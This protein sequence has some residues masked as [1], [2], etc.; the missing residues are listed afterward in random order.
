MPLRFRQVVAPVVVWLCLSF[1]AAHGAVT[2]YDSP[3]GGFT[4][5]PPTGWMI[6]QEAG[7]TYPT[8]SGPA[9]DLR[10]P[11]IV[12]KEVKGEKD[13]YSL[14]DATMKEMLK[15]PRY[16]MSVRDAFQTSDQA[17]GLKYVLTVSAPS[18]T[19]GAPYRQIYYFVDG[20][21]GRIF[22]ILATVPETGWKLY[23][24][25]IDTMVKTYH[26]YPIPSPPP[27]P[28]SST[29]TLAPGKHN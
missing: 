18:S 2:L 27:P 19:G 21:P 26:L 4:L 9:D 15:D 12:I 23:G 1:A 20:P 17:F 3:E 22:A 11:Y 6:K 5:I 25:V 7:E 14:G 24:P 13:I 10:A 29:P 8:L 28:S 16:Q